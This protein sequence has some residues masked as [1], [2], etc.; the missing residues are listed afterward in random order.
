MLLFF[1]IILNET[2]DISTTKSLVIVVRYYKDGYICDRFLGLI[3]I[4]IGSAENLF[5]AIFNF[6]AEN[7]I[8][9]ENLIGFAAD[10]ASVMQGNK[11]GLRAKFREII[12]HIFVL[13]CSC[14]SFNLCASAAC[15]KLPSSVEKLCRDICNYF[16]NSSV[17]L[18]NLKEC[19]IFVHLEPHKMLK[20]SQTRWLS[21]QT[22]V[23]RILEQWSA[24]KL[25][26]TSEAEDEIGNGYF[27]SA[28]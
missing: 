6:F 9:I 12:P 21:L 19:Q 10:N 20:L 14:H 25:F 24:L 18:A 8:N 28:K 2:T 17:R 3:K 4:I 1:S 26:F 11:S 15:S 16:S 5:Y 22:V 27:R 7:N 23:N 13:G